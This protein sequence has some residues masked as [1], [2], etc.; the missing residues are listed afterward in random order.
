[1]RTASI[2]MA[3]LISFVLGGCAI[4]QGQ[5]GPHVETNPAVLPLRL[6]EVVALSRQGLTDDVVIAEIEQRGIAFV[7]ARSDF[8]QLQSAGFSDGLLRYLQ[9][10]ASAES[11]LRAYLLA[12]RYRTPSYSGPLYLGYPYLGYHDGLH[13]YGS[14]ERRYYGGSHFGTHLGGHHGIHNGG[15][16]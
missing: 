14:Y 5:P 10:Q 8:E 2:L 11:K 15:H 3:L 12:G 4:A 6:D 13:S 16:H 7:L 9:G 1:M